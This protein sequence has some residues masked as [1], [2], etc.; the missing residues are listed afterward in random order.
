[1]PYMCG[2]SVFK[3]KGRLPCGDPKERARGYRMHWS[4]FLADVTFKVRQD[5]SAYG[6][7]SCSYLTWAASCL[8][9]VYFV[10]G[11]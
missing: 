10:A 3:Y 8:H 9:F 11:Q 1:M 2:R 4:S 5:N 7:D 6:S